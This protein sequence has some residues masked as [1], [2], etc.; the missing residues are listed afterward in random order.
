M[1]LAPGPGG[2]LIGPHDGSVRAALASERGSGDHGR[3]DGFEPFDA[4]A[5]EEQV[6]SP[7][8]SRFSATLFLYWAILARIPATTF[9]GA[10]ARNSELD[11]CCSRAAICFAN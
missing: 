11:N 1:P 10:L 7:R 3:I 6:H 4:T 5:R 8:A 9:S 2:L